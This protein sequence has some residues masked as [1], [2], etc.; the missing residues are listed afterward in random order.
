MPLS[1]LCLWP[2]GRNSLWAGLCGWLPAGHGNDCKAPAPGGKC[3]PLAFIAWVPPPQGRQR[4]GVCNSLSC[5]QPWLPSRGWPPPDAVAMLEPLRSPHSTCPLGLSLERSH[6]AALCPDSVSTPAACFSE[7]SSPF[8][9]VCHSRPG[10][11][12]STGVAVT[13]SGPQ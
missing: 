12:A 2:L 3:R 9:T 6:L 13:G 8:T 4:A 7:P 10:I 5:H 11:S 1:V